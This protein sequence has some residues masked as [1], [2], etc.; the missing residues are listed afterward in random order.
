[1]EIYFHLGIPR[2]ASKFFDQRLYWKFQDKDIIVN[3]PEF[4]EFIRFAMYEKVNNETLR[5]AKEDIGNI[6][7]KM[8][9]K[10]ILIHNWIGMD[11]WLQSYGDYHTIIKYI[12]PDAKVIMMM[13]YQVD[14]IVSL[15]NLS[16]QK[17]CYQDIKGFLNYSNN[18]FNPVIRR[19]LKP[20]EGGLGVR[21]N[22]LDI[23][24]VHIPDLLEQYYNTFGEDN[25]KILFFED[26]LRNKKAVVDDICKYIGVSTPNIDNFS[27]IG[28]SP[29]AFT[30]KLMHLIYYGFGI[31]TP[32]FTNSQERKNRN[33]FA[34]AYMSFAVRL[35]QL[36]FSSNYDISEKRNLDKLFY[37]NWD[38]LKKGGLRDKLDKIFKEDNKKLLKFIP[39][40][41]IPDAYL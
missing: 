14:W 9:A 3:P 36:I 16:C 18:K 21:K 6:L 17:Q 11:P 41:R 39:R 25:F 29:S 5:K 12:F 20:N 32:S 27:P 1:M 8:T 4:S 38:I 26:F 13:R 19:L 24:T 10:K 31:Y 30:S 23:N 22:R 34:R 7:R 33:F 28:R 35:N 2:T 15:Y 40:E 37:Y